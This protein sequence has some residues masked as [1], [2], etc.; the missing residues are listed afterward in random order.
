MGPRFQKY[1]EYVTPLRGPSRSQEGIESPWR[2]PVPISGKVFLSGV[3]LG[4]ANVMWSRHSEFGNHLS[5]KMSRWMKSKAF[6]ESM[7]AG[8]VYP[9]RWA[10]T[11]SCRRDETEHNLFTKPTFHF[12]RSRGRPAIAHLLPCRGLDCFSPSSVSSPNLPGT[13]SLRI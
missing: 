3:A 13:Q 11:L 6:L 10:L 1:V 9:L 5:M 2:T 4:T 12:L 8:L 7:W